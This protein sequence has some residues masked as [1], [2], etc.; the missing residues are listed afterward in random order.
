MLS[1][2]VNRDPDQYSG[3]SDEHDVRLISYLVDLLLL[4]QTAVFPSDGMKP[5]QSV[6]ENRSFVGRA[7]TG[8]LPDDD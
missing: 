5:G 4:R 3:V 2:D 6:L 8:E 1:A 7:V